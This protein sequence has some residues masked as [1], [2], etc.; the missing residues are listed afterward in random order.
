MPRLRRKS[1]TRRSSEAP[2]P[3]WP[4]EA[5]ATELDWLKANPDDLNR[6][7]IF[8]RASEIQNELDRRAS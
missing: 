3:E 6:W 2:L 1:K 4:T 7:Q 5:L 8:K